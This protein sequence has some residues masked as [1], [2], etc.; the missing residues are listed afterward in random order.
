MNGSVFKRCPCTENGK[1]VGKK[2]RACKKDHGSWYFVHDMA[3]A[4]G[5][6][7]RIRRG[8]YHTKEAAEQALA[9]SLAKCAQRGVAVERDL[10]GGRQMVADYLR[11][12]IEGKKG[13][14]PSTKRSYRMH[15]ETHLIP[16]LGMARLDEL[17]V[18]HIDEAY[19]QLRAPK[20]LPPRPRKRAPKPLGP[21]RVRKDGA[22]RLGPGE[23][24][25][26]VK[27]YLV[28]HP[29]MNF[30]P[31]E[32]ARALGRDRNCGAIRQRLAKLAADGE[33]VQVSSKPRRYA[34]DSAC[35]ASHA[36]GRPVAVPA[37]R[38][39]AASLRRIH[40]T[41]RKALNDAVH[42]RILDYNPAIYAELEPAEP[43]RVRY[44]THEEAGRFLDAIVGERLYALYHLAVYRGLRRGELIA[45]RWPDV[46][47]DDG[48]IEI[49]RNIVQL[50][51]QTE[52][53]APKSGESQ[54]LIALDDDTIAVLRAHRD[55]QQKERAD[56]GQQW[57]ADSFVFATAEGGSLN[58][59]YVSRHLTALIKTVAVPV[60]TLHQLRHT[61]ASLMLEAGADLKYVQHV[62]GHSSI[63][64]TAKLY[65]HITRRL[66]LK[67]SRQVAAMIPRKRLLPPDEGG[68]LARIA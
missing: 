57:A 37:R 65:V 1:R 45:L 62:L 38:L 17:G 31:H 47:L 68:V 5:S 20:P 51:K 56:L 11:G 60:I 32:V 18:G 13:L 10:A 46:D 53:G 23:L 25:G 3:T 49:R 36:A 44:W 59:D 14:K 39:S 55:R 30:A 67:R 40:C 7:R 19:E 24:R 48:F 50:G 6:R 4:D 43:P 28:S 29:D 12:W 26:Q 42:K 27:A 63:Y 33:I 21:A 66:D 16:L 61:A 54:R 2:A 64:I 41:L 9:K 35:E 8:G 15:I 34:Y 52:E 58:P 22:P